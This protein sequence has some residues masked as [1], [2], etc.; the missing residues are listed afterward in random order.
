MKPVLLTISGPVAVGIIFLRVIYFVGQPD[1]GMF[2]LIALSLLLAIAVAIVA[3]RPLIV[4]HPTFWTIGLTSPAFSLIMACSF[5]VFWAMSEE[6]FIHVF[7]QP[8][9]LM[10]GIERYIYPGNSGMGFARGF[11]QLH[12][13]LYDA[14]IAG[15]VVGVLWTPISFGL[16]AILGRPKCNANRVDGS[17]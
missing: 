13:S 1:A 15:I 11:S 9:A 10:P 6:F 8:S 4:P 5:A 14:G 12:R 2:T 7:T 17:D 16:F 3:V